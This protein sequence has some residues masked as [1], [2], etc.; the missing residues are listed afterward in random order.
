MSRASMRARSLPINPHRILVAKAHEL[1]RKGIKVYDY[2]A[3]QPGLPP[4]REAL[5]YFTEMIKRD[6]FKHFRYMPTQ[7]LQELRDAIAQDLKKYGGIDVSPSQIL[8]TAGGAE[9]LY[10]STLSLL[11]EEMVSCC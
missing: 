2:T 9:A 11:N 6:P 10:L 5:E 3:G 1:S 8:V 4:S 7:G